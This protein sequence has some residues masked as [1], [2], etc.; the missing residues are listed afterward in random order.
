MQMKINHMYTAICA[1]KE[2]M[3]AL[4]EYMRMLSTQQL[5]DYAPRHT[6]KSTRSSKRWHPLKCLT[7][8]K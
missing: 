8:L 3:D 1:L 6:Q 7:N 2:D 5:P 4:Y